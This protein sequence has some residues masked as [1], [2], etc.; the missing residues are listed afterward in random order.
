MP[1]RIDPPIPLVGPPQRYDW[2]ADQPLTRIHGRTR[3]LCEFNPTP[4]GQDYI[5]GGRFDA[6][7]GST[8]GY[9]YAADSDRTAVGETLVTFSGSESRIGNTVLTKTLENKKIG[10][11]TLNSGLRLV[12][13]VTDGGLAAIGQDQWLTQC[14]SSDYP[15]TRK[16]CASIRRRANWAQG[17]IWKSRRD[18]AGHSLMLFEDRCQ[19]ENFTVVPTIAQLDSNLH[20]GSAR[21][22]IQPHLDYFEA[23]ELSPL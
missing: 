6:L 10:R 22:L 13:L 7:K 1:P 23:T 2:R 16:W 4:R 15:L 20:D 18:P 3:G 11:F 17:L 9:L 5:G 14:D 8:F 21:A 19:P 12:D